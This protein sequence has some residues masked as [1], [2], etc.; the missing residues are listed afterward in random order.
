MKRIIPFLLVISA[1]LLGSCTPTSNPVPQAVNPTEVHLQAEFKL[2]SEFV[3]DAPATHMQYL[4]WLP[5]GFGEDP[6]KSWP[7]IFFL[8]GSGSGTNDSAYVI[9][10]GLPEVLYTGEQPEDFPFVV[11][12]PQAFT[13]LPWWGG[14]TPDVLLALLDEVIELYRIDPDRVYLTGLSMGGYGSW[15][16]AAAYP[17]RFAAVVSA[18]G[19]GYGDVNPTL[20]QL[21]KV[22]Q[23][24]L[25]AFHGALD[26][27][28]DPI[29]AKMYMVS[30]QTECDDIQEVK[31]TLYPDEG[32]LGTY[33]KAYRDPELYT[34]LLAQSLGD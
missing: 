27:I 6:D 28:S 9:G 26:A 12:S 5:K 33:Q 16:M 21:C 19:T 2:S 29:G 14:V 30:L 20:E 4:V 13:G 34:W 31:W 1:F 8:H 11:I 32:H 7:M 15:L 22:G 18:A 10:Q 17:E 25:W 24:P 3:L 23:T